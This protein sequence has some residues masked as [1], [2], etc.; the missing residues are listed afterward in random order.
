MILQELLNR[1]L[2][3]NASDVHLV[4]GMPPLFRIHTVLEPVEGYDRLTPEQTEQF[5]KEMVTPQRFEELIERRDL[6]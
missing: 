3:E 1:A 6:V 5:V 2:D 4:A